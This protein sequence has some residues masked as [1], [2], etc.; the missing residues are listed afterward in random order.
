M[1]NVLGPD[2]QQQ[3]VALGRL[4]WSLRRIEQATGVRRE[5]IS[6]YLRTAGVPVRGR[7]RPR[8][9]TTGLMVS[10]ATAKPAMSPTAVSSTDLRPSPAPVPAPACRTASSSAKRSGASV[11]RPVVGP[12]KSVHGRL[13]RVSSYS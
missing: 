5:T 12:T 4:G 6:G 11:F 8:V 2:K 1:G 10:E 13:P 7:W 9:A 3:V